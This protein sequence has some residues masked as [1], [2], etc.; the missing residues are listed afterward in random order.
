MILGTHIEAFREEVET[1]IR[2]FYAYE[3]MSKLLSEQLYVNLVNHNV[4]FWK[5]FLSSVQTKLFIA[6]GRLY[7]DSNDAFSFQ[8]FIKT[9]RE[10]IEEFGRES[11]E[12]RRLSD[13]TTRPDW[14]DNYLSDAYF[15]KVE[16]IDALARMARPFNKKMKGL[17]KEIRS[18]VFAHAI[19]TDQIVISN[20][21]EGTNFEEIDSDLTALWSIYSQARQLYHNAHQPTLKIEAYPYKDEV[22]ECV[23]I[24][25]IGKV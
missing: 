20:L 13:Y 10:N 5:I 16:D 25:V 14:L 22:D 8:S 12:K 4:Y 19:H 6:L 24:A 15:A 7:D 9:C 2:V 11:F 1:A 18:K 3:A 23:R 21:F 17:Y